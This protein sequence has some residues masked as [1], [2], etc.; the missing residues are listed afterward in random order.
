MNLKEEYNKAVEAVAALVTE[1]QAALAIERPRDYESK[2]RVLY[3]EY[4]RVLHL[5]EQSV[6]DVSGHLE[7]D[8]ETVEVEDV[9]FDGLTTTKENVFLYK[10]GLKFA[11]NQMQAARSSIEDD[12]ELV[13]LSKV[14]QQ[15][16]DEMIKAKLNK[17]M[18]V[19]F[20]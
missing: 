14:A 17:G 2:Q 11:A 18:Q 13:H 8:L 16:A 20:Y 10:T 12:G 7:S 9:G 15:Y 6:V 1:K 3:L 5:I 4:A 19:Q